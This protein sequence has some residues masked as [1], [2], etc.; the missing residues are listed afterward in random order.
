MKGM[1]A[2]MR[3]EIQAAGPRRTGGNGEDA[4]T[5]DTLAETVGRVASRTGEIDGLRFEMTTLKSKLKRMEESQ[6]IPGTPAPSTKSIPRSEPPVQQPPP[7][8]P[9]PPPPSRHQEIAPRGWNAVNT[10]KRKS[11]GDSPPFA[12]AKRPRTDYRAPNGDTMP[13]YAPHVAPSPQPQALAPMR[14]APQDSWPNDPTRLPPI[15]GVPHSSRSAIRPPP[16]R[17][18]PSHELSTADWER[19]SWDHARVEN[20][21]YYRPLAGGAPLSPGAAKRGNLIRRGTSGG[22]APL[23]YVDPGPAKRTRQRP[24][25][26]EQG[27][28][29]RKDGKPDQRS[30]SSPQN[31]RKVHER[32]IQEQEKGSQ[33]SPEDP[34]SPADTEA[35][36][37]TGAANSV[38]GSSAS[39]SPALE[40][41]SPVEAPD[42]RPPTPE[43]GGSRPVSKHDKVMHK[44]FPHG[45]ADGVDRM[46]HAAHIFEHDSQDHQRVELREDIERQEA[47]EQRTAAYE[48]MDIDQSHDERKGKAIEQHETQ[49]SGSVYEPSQTQT[50]EE[51]EPKKKVILRL[52]D[53]S[54]SKTSAK[55]A[56]DSDNRP[57][58][59][60]ELVESPVETGSSTT[61]PTEDA[62]G[63]VYEP[64]Q[65]S[66][67]EE[68][69]AA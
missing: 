17:V 64:S 31:L 33:G 36:R 21:S 45:I 28:L 66:P 50:Q 18:P 24:I 14:P 53:P 25:R 51:E 2:E 57:L 69:S 27:V 13:G 44:M 62:T 54:N 39:G 32:R 47:H 37:S 68:K 41:I 6:G 15:R 65:A 10:S 49:A 48:H 29:I 42:S 34:L 38:I 43:N 55:A 56:Q 63:S 5:L 35:P 20:D 9:P 40:Q 16:P 61:S 58:R 19:E 22:G 3:Y 11:L 67:V 60:R 1:L 7:P 23:T 46:N 12:E 30:I 8:P 59:V 52:S 4:S 26:N